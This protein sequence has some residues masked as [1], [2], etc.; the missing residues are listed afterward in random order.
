M[1][2]FQE[3]IN[4][5]TSVRGRNRF[6]HSFKIFKTF[7]LSTKPF[8]VFLVMFQDMR[9]HRYFPKILYESTKF[10]PHTNC[11]PGVY[12]L[13]TC[14]PCEQLSSSLKLSPIASFMHSI[15]EEIS[16]CLTVRT[17]DTVISEYN[18][19]NKQFPNG[20]EY[21]TH[22]LQSSSYTYIS[23]VSAIT[24]NNSCAPAFMHIPRTWDVL[25]TFKPCAHSV[26]YHM[27]ISYD[28][29]GLRILMWNMILHL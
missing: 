5:V 26:D 15:L 6:F 9:S 7:Q 19:L 29:N 21:T 23:H 8:T 20:I 2:Q 11:K 16:T 12:A 18:T 14:P 1:P 28:E 4:P 3:P 25:I 27:Y 17:L 10:T 24:P 13:L 22:L